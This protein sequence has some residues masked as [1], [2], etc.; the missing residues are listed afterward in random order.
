VQTPVFIVHAFSHSTIGETTFEKGEV[1]PKRGLTSMLPPM[2]PMRFRALLGL[3]TLS[4]FISP[5]ARG[6]D[7]LDYG[8]YMHTL[9]EFKTLRPMRS[10]EVQGSLAYVAGDSSGL[11]ILDVSVPSDPILL[12]TAGTTAAARDV[13]ISGDLAYVAASESGLLVVNIADPANPVVVG[14]VDT[15]GIARGVALEGDYAYVADRDAGGLQVVDVSNPM[16]P[17]LVGSMDTPGR[18]YDVAV[19]NHRA[20]V[21]D[22]EPGV[23]I[24]DVTNPALPAAIGTADTPNEAWDV[25]VADTLA[26]VADR[27]SGLQILDVSNP[28][29]PVLLGGINIANN[30]VYKVVVRGNTAFVAGDVFGLRVFDVSNPSAPAFMGGVATFMGAIGVAVDENRAY[31]V[32]YPPF[33]PTQ[34][35]GMTVIDITNPVSPPGQVQN[36]NGDI[37]KGI[38]VEGNRAYTLVTGGFF[39]LKIADASNPDSL[40]PLGQFY[41]GSEPRSFSVFGNL[42]CIAEGFGIRFVDV[43]NPAMPVGKG[44]ISRYAW[45]VAISGTFAYAVTTDSLNFKVIDI[46]NPDSP[47]IVGAAATTARAVAMAIDG[48]HA[49]VTEDGGRLEI[50][51]ISNPTSPV[52]LGGLDLTGEVVDVTASGNYAFIGN[53]SEGLSIVDVSDPAFPTLTGTVDTP[54]SASAV[55]IAGQT[56]YVSD[57]YSLQV[58]D[59]VNPS[60]PFLIGTTFMALTNSLD[61]SGDFVYVSG[62]QGVLVNP[63]QC[64]GVVPVALTQFE[65]TPEPGAIGLRWRTTDDFDNAGFYVHRSHLSGPY[66]RITPSLLP[67]P[68][69]YEFRDTHVAEGKAYS[70][71]LEAV[72]RDGRSTYL[73]PWTVLTSS[74]TPR[75]RLGQSRPNP[76]PAGQSSAWIDFDLARPGRT[77]VRV[78]DI[79][80]AQV[81]VLTDAVLRAGTHS[82]PWDGMDDRGH[83]TAAGAYFYQIV[84]GGF[85]KTRKL[86]LVR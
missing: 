9:G 70:Y 24:V 55:E 18:A 82:I 20:Y 86:I 13:K 53:G 68:G 60:H 42:A 46:S 5:A 59:I 23:Q 2:N 85:S 25:F 6:S 74:A 56:A 72:S 32:G 47:M 34:P 48:G 71:K 40:L 73:G 65:A 29:S 51:D 81:R 63:V 30:T 44:V 41:L 49:Y 27:S 4:V 43:S 7:C 19:S 35:A 26:Y 21:A 52:V 11:L 8:A 77:L 54:G 38:R 69:P 75:N 17:A 39:Y 1:Y 76:F 33:F 36:M 37:V 31:V 84:S 57:G 79:S 15:P 78:L 12:G 80:G 67:S 28:V 16:L 61:V 66:E 14:S 64:Q 50:L 3:A 62:A 10:I 83:P 22:G 58:I 45:D